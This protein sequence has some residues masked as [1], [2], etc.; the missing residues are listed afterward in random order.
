MPLRVLSGIL[1]SAANPD[2]AHLRRRYVLAM[3]LS[4]MVGVSMSV[5]LAMDSPVEAPTRT[6]YLPAD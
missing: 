1:S 5:W 2:H 6:S 3:A 4:V